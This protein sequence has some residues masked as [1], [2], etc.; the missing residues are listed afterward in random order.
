[1]VLFKG[2]LVV[3]CFLVVGLL[4]GL[5]ADSHG[6]MTMTGN[7]SSVAPFGS[8]SI[9]GDIFFAIRFGFA[10]GGAF[11]GTFV[12]AFF[13]ADFFAGAFFAALAGSFNCSSWI[14]SSVCSRLSN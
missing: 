1:M 13:G 9:F 7:S 8:V 12:A 5:L 2:I 11:F 14:F 4:V 10:F 3:G 6:S